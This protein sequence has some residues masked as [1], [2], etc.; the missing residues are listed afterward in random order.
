MVRAS[1]G[2]RSLSFSLNVKPDRSLRGQRYE[3]TTE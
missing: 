2:P 1:I 3:T